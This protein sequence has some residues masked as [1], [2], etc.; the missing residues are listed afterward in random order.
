MIVFPTDQEGK[1][2]LAG[3]V[4]E[5]Y[6]KGEFELILSSGLGGGNTLR[7]SRDE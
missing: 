2:T 5:L 3:E 6:E 1:P 4:K 7:Q